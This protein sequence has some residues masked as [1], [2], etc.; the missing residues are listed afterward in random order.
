MI[1]AVLL[2]LEKDGKIVF[3]RR[4]GTKQSLPGRWSLPSEKIEPGEN[5]ETAVRRCAEHE[6][7]L[8]NLSNITKY[9][10]IEVHKEGE[11]KILY[12]FK[13]NY[14]GHPFPAA[15]N[16]LTKL[17]HHTFKD[18]FAKYKDEEIGRGLQYLRAKMNY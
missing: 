13:A 15:Q 5:L 4:A 6:L 12:F 9:D 3:G 14:E 1:N 7:N 17:E 10:Q 8:L 18:F 2:I 11:D 16:E